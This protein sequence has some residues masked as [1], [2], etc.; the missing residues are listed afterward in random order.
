M[1]KLIVVVLC[2]TSIMICLSLEVYADEDD[3]TSYNEVMMV[4]GKLLD[5]FTEEELEYYYSQ[6]QKRMF[7]GTRV[8]VANQNVETT[9]ISSTLYS[10]DNQGDTNVDYE[11]NIVVETA[12]KVTWKVSGSLSGTAKS[13]LKSFKG[14]LAAKVGIEYNS[15]TTE[16]RKETQKMKVTVEKGSRA[17]VYLMG[18]ARVTNGVCACYIMFV[19]TVT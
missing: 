8:A 15:Q 13:T 2:L 3:Y 10:V 1:K 12:T 18:S 11:L 4:D 19:R 17:I 9:Y 7:W 5:N 14:D 6:V 16:S